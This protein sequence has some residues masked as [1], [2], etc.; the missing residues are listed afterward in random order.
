MASEYVLYYGDY[1][2]NFNDD[3]NW[4]NLDLDYYYGYSRSDENHNPNAAK[5]KMENILAKIDDCNYVLREDENT[6][7]ETRNQIMNKEDSIKRVDQKSVCGIEHTDLKAALEYLQ[8]GF[9]NDW[10]I[11]NSLRMEDF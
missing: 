7:T 8:A 4:T 9:Q 6:G 5:E 2:Y 3:Y 10:K 11:S 1:D